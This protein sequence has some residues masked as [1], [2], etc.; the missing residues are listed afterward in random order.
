MTNP[1]PRDSESPRRN[2]RARRLAAQLREELA[3]G[4]WPIG[5]RLPPV[6][7]LAAAHG[8]AF[9]TVRKAL[10]EL[11]DD[12]QLQIK[13]RSGAYVK[14]LPATAAPTAAVGLITPNSAF[15]DPVVDSAEAVL[16]AAGFELRITFA[17]Y[18]RTVEFERARSLVANGAQGLIIAPTLHL[19]GD[20]I[21]H[22]DAFTTLDV[23][24]VLVERHP[25]DAPP[26]A[27]CRRTPYV[28]SDITEGLNQ[29]IC[30]LHA[31]G[32]RRIGFQGLLESSHADEI[33]R[34]YHSAMTALEL[35]VNDQTVLRRPPEDW[36]DADVAH[37]ARLVVEHRLDAVVC[38]ADT[39]AI[40]LLPHLR[41]ARVEVPGD[42][43]I[44]TYD[45]QVA[46]IAEIPLTTIVPARAQIGALAA[47]A[48]AAMIRDGTKAP[49]VRTRVLPHF[50][51]RESTVGGGS[52]QTERS[53][54]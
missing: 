40:R 35:P 46:G 26:Q 44:V 11:A 38:V 19:D 53:R 39:L 43:A 37:Y 8:V 29:A 51:V 31:Q 22:L 47:A 10:F 33:F 49:I 48:L 23:P 5:S 18:D 7:D 16:H 27:P 14:A 17:G 41:R 15:Y 12:G 42:L 28:C 6:T 45:D 1:P 50:V 21:A 4:R 25:V 36:S 9:D 3:S 20:P 30:H 2:T 13:P 34:A 32:R 52:A 24:H 54:A